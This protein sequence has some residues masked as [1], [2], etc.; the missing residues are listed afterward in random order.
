MSCVLT[1]HN[2]SLNRKFLSTTLRLK[3]IIYS[4]YLGY[5][6]A[7]LKNLYRIYDTEFD[8]TRKLT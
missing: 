4:L 6:D 3:A 7:F 2:Q 1:Y 8:R 5:E